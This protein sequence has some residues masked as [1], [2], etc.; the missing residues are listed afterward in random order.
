MRKYKICVAIDGNNSSWIVVDN[1]TFI[2]NPTKEDLK[3]AE[4]KVYSND[5]ICSICREENSITDKSILYPG[6]S[7]RDTDKNG[8]KI[9]DRVCK[10]HALKNY[11]RYDPNSLE[12][13]KKRLSSR[14]MGC[15]ND[16]TKILGDDCEELT[17]ILFGVKRLSIEYD[18]Y[19]QLPLDHS[20]IP[21]GVYATIA[22]EIVELSGKTPLTRGRYYDQKRKRWDAASI[23]RDWYKKFDILIFYCISKDG[24][25]I[26]RIYIFPIYEIINRKCISA[27][28]S[29]TN[30]A[31]YEKY[32]VSGEEELK[33]ANKFWNEIISRRNSFQKINGG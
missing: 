17:N 20:P 21:N 29:P 10:K 26:E 12:N 22:G 14:R 8:K 28:N 24:K 7:F 2:R 3:G 11:K 5:N 30:N 13:L 33:K 31:W 25:V 32:R 4:F 15:L 9:D 6:N 19:S 16:H 1:G 23:E 18:K 27:Y